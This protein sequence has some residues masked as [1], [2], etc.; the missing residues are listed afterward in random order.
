MTLQQF[1]LSKEK[2][3]SFLMLKKIDDY[4]IRPVAPVIESFIIAALH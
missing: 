1:E 2:K 3:V 4:F